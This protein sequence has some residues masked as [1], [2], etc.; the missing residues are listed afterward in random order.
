MGY[1]FMEAY[2]GSLYATLGTADH[3]SSTQQ[4]AVAESAWRINGYSVAWLY[5]QWPISGPD[6]T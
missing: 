5:S 3:W 2:G 6:C 1:G 4:I